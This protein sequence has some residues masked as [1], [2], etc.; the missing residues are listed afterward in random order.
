HSIT[1][2]DQV[3]Q[4]LSAAAVQVLGGARPV[5]LPLFSPRSASIVARAAR[6]CGATAPL[7]L[8]GLSAAVLAAWDGP[9]PVAAVSVAEP[10][11]G[12]MAAE[13]LAQSGAAS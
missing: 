5:I 12:A 8:I 6:A 10:T 9:A 1:V 13:I 7:R 4:D 2:Y 3:E 11:A